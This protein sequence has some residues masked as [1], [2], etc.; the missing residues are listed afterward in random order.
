MQAGR[1]A[2]SS[3][4]HPVASATQISRP[5]S[6]PATTHLEQA[7][8]CQRHLAAH[9]AKAGDEAVAG[10]PPAVHL[11]KHSV[12]DCRGSEGEAVRW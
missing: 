9:L 8:G 12:G 6:S 7:H 10:H 2:R 5:A 3:G 1:R 11:R 4:L